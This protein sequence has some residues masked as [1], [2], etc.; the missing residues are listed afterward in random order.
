MLK[1]KWFVAVLVIAG[2][3]ICGYFEYVRYSVGYYDLPDNISETASIHSF[4][5]GLRGIFLIRQT[6][7]GLVCARLLASL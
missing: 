1:V 4:K 5:G 6:K 7:S 2:I 3:G